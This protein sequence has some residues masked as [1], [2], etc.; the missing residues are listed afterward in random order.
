MLTVIAGWISVEDQAIQSICAVISSTLFTFGEGF[1]ESS[2]SLIGNMIGANRV[3]YAWHYAQAMTPLSILMTILVLIP[4]FNNMHEM[5]DLFTSEPGMRELLM[6]VLPILLICFFFDVLQQQSK[7]VIRGLN[8]Q[9]GAV[10]ITLI[11]Y[12]VVAIPVGLCFAFRQGKGVEGLRAG[13]LVG[14][15][16]LVTLQSILIDCLTNWQNIAH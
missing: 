9:R 3:G 11:G 4:L 12:Y 5:A 2:S 6:Q 1:S 15:L 16:V 7:G 10:W 13:V 8:L 14:Q